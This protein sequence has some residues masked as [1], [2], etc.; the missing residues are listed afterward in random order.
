M[1][2]EC[3]FAAQAESAIVNRRRRSAFMFLTM[4]RRAIA[5]CEAVHSPVCSV[6]MRLLPILIILGCHPEQPA[7]AHQDDNYGAT[8]ED[9]E[10]WKLAHSER[11][12]EPVRAADCTGVKEYLADFPKGKH[13]SD[14]K[15]M[16][17]ALPDRLAKVPEETQW[18]KSDVAECK[19][20]DDVESCDDIA[21][22]LKR[23]PM[24][25]HA[26]E[27]RALLDAA[28]PKIEKLQQEQNDAGVEIELLGMDHT[29]ADCPNA[30]E[31]ALCVVLDVRLRHN[32]K[33]TAVGVMTNCGEKPGAAKKMYWATGKDLTKIPL[34]A[35]SDVHVA[36]PRAE[37]CTIEVGIGT[38][39]KLEKQGLRRICLYAKADAKD[40]HAEPGSCP[41]TP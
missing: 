12:A 9:D 24:G 21:D 11:C 1:T 3:G 34:G 14:A 5:R 32:V 2:V 28:K 4:R 37:R 25:K 30:F 13:A 16:L 29:A 22:Y 20:A 31:G 33:Q 41:D 7:T 15:Y 8:I 26:A 38:L 17:A 6:S 35:T 10:A 18:T 19:A 39:P 36:V 40:D 23:M 27:A